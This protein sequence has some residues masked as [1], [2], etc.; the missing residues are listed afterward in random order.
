MPPTKWLL[1]LVDGSA[2]EVWAHAV[3]GLPGDDADRDYV[4]GSLIDIDIDIVDHEQFEISD[5]YTEAT[6]ES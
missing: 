2:V 1:A 6:G 3:S 5:Y 4:F